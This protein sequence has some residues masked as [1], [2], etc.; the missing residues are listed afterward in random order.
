[1]L[2]AHIHQSSKTASSNVDQCSL[3][4][5]GRILR[6]DS[7]T[8]FVLQMAITRADWEGSGNHYAA[9][10]RQGRDRLAQAVD[11]HQL[12]QP[13][14][15][16]SDQSLEHAE[17]RR[18]VSDSPPSMKARL[19]QRLPGLRGSQPVRAGERRNRHPGHPVTKHFEG[20]AQQFTRFTRLAS[21]RWMKSQKPSSSL[22]T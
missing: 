22:P 5:A 2:C 4:E 17:M 3:L 11:T 15:L 10:R 14:A 20:C 19:L 7:A 18:P 16:R 13:G 12:S 8:S 21:K 1:M 6:G 9:R